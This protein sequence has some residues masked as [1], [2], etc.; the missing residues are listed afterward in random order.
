MKTK[1]K[2]LYRW[3]RTGIAKKLQDVCKQDVC[4]QDVCK[5]CKTKLD[6]HRR[7]GPCWEAELKA[8]RI[9]ETQFQQEHPE[10]Y[11][12]RE[13]NAIK[14]IVLLNLLNPP[15]GMSRNKV[16]EIYGEELVKEMEGEIQSMKTGADFVPLMNKFRK[17]I[18]DCE[19][20]KGAS[21]K[22]QGKYL[23]YL[24]SGKLAF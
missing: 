12:R 4:K 24:L 13:Q 19:K 23:S 6:V 20:V 11:K 10:E 7:C 8:F 14:L 16:S 17:K 3:A 21:P 22:W 15:F 2:Q 9:N 5:N 18:H 1:L